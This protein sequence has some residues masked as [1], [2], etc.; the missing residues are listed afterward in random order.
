MRPPSILDLVQAVSE[1]APAHP[2]VAA[3]WYTRVADL[4]SP[5]MVVVIE[6]ID[7]S[8]ADCAAIGT[9]LQRRLRPD[10]VA[11]RPH[12]AAAEAATLYRL[13]TAPGRRTVTAG[14]GEE[15]A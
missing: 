15:T 5:P 10:A 4:G 6:S 11:V 2:E 8:E 12:R 1:L 14:P 13:L 7:G 9:E 3:W